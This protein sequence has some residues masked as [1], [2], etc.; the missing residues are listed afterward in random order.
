MVATMNGRVLKY[1]LVN[2]SAYPPHMATVGAAGYD[3]RTPIDFVIKARDNHVVDVGVALELPPHTYAQVKSRSGMAFKHQVVV[4]AGVIDNDY[5]GTIAVLLFNHGKKSRVYRR[6]DKIA[7]IVV[8]EYCCLPLV[9]SAE[10]S[11]TERDT[12]GFGSTGR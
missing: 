5:R 2:K 12:D 4:G 3:L 6:G 11:N 10:L 1:K 9:E 7:Q 8:Q